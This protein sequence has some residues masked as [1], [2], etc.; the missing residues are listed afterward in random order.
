M[1]KK[2]E[3]LHWWW[4]SLTHTHLW[5]VA[6]P[7]QTF[8]CTLTH[9]QHPPPHLNNKSRFS[10]CHISTVAVVCAFQTRKPFAWF[11]FK[12][13]P[14]VK[15]FCKTKKLQRIGRNK[16]IHPVLPYPPHR[17]QVL[18]CRD[19]TNA[20]SCWPY[21]CVGSPLCA[22]TF[23]ASLQNDL[24]FVIIGQIDRSGSPP[25]K[26]HSP[27]PHI[28][29][30]NV[31]NPDDVPPSSGAG[32]AFVSFF[33]PSLSSW[34]K[35]P[36]KTRSAWWRWFNIEGLREGILARLWYINRCRRDCVV[37]VRCGENKRVFHKHQR[38]HTTTRKEGPS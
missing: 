5:M 14:R 36:N 33:H 24:V 23:A 15:P 35:Q 11:L 38:K 16:S 28:C 1:A 9:F 20:R 13:A 29:L 31:R 18:K 22:S 27:L 10:E 34:T 25:G 21:R 2:P 32:L 19:D 12:S 6:I 30:E 8:L 3:S 26:R 17:K 37:L 4:R 7:I